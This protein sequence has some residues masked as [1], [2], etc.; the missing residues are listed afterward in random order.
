MAY[1]ETSF[2]SGIA[3]G[4]AMKGVSMANP[5]R[6]DLL[7]V[8]SGRLAAARIVALRPE[9]VP[10]FTGDSAAVTSFL[11]DLNGQHIR[12]SAAVPGGLGIGSL[13]AAAVLTQ[14]GEL[15]CAS[16]ALPGERTDAFG[17]ALRQK[18]ADRSLRAAEA[19]GGLGGLLQ[20]GAAIAIED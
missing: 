13:S 5:N 1:D 19:P 15:I 9:T 16:A 2:L 12:A 10:G 6:G 11:A 4:R 14:E 3:L 17:A 18:A 7:R 8:L 20:A